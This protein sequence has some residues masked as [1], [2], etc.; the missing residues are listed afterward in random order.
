M[1]SYHMIYDDIMKSYDMLPGLGHV[2]EIEINAC[3]RLEKDV[4]TY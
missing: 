3:T 4:R 2:V 1:I